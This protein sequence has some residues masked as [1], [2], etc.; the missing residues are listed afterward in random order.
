MTSS[1]LLHRRTEGFLRHCCFVNRP[2]FF[3]DR[4]AARRGADR[5]PA[6]QSH[7]KQSEPHSRSEACTFQPAWYPSTSGQANHWVG[8]AHLVKI[9]RSLSPVPQTEPGC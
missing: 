5:D 9:R 2:C 8:S 6:S 7:T 4:R 3:P 1:H